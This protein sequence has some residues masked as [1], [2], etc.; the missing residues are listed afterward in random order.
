MSQSSECYTEES[1]SPAPSHAA[2]IRIPDDSLLLNFTSCDP[3]KIL[4]NPILNDCCNDSDVSLCVGDTFINILELY[5][6][7]TLINMNMSI[8]NLKKQHNCENLKNTRIYDMLDKFYLDLPD[9]VAID[10]AWV[11][12]Q[13]VRSIIDKEN[14]H[15]AIQEHLN[16]LRFLMDGNECDKYCRRQSDSPPITK[17]ECLQSDCLKQRPEQP[18]QTD[19]P[20]PIL[21]VVNPD[22]SSDNIEDVNLNIKNFNLNIEDVN[23]NTADAEIS[24][25]FTQVQK[26]KKG[27]KKTKKEKM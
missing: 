25:E 9:V 17:R 21:N 18:K 7:L 15:H 10:A 16:R 26:K 23:L 2:E 27:N 6:D 3:T 19:Q 20:N 12:E 13:S 14:I 22:V 5:R 11:S 1:S 24:E 8:S 4:D